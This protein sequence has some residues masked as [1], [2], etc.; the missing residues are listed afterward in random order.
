M[1]KIQIPTII[2]LLFLI[3]GVAAGVLSVQTEQVDEI[4]AS[5]NPTPKNVRVSN[6]SGFSASISW[7][8]DA[9]TNGFVVWDDDEAL[10][11][12][13]VNQNGNKGHAH[14]L[15]INDL[16][17]SRKYYFEIISAGKR[18]DNNGIPWQFKTGPTLPAPKSS[19]FASG[20]VLSTTG[21]PVENALVY[22]S[23]GGSSLLSTTTGE[24]GSWLIP[25]SN[26]RDTNLTSYKTINKNSL[27]EISVFAG[28]VYGNAS[29]QVYPH[30]AN[31]MPPIILGSFHDFKSLSS[32]GEGSVPSADLDLPTEPYESK[33]KFE[34]EV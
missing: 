6:I 4:S 18:S 20:K 22:L 5:G 17:P 24:G 25:I 8:T 12:K 19:R 33:F 10:G 23:V 15:A 28:T 16:N 31:S 1:N 21:H 7:T 13:T 32:S 29:A 27:V 9:K 30:S 14:H 3:A 34:E 2:A 11:R 26:A